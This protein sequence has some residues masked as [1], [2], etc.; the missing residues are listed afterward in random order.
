MTKILQD[1]AKKKVAIEASKLISDHMKLGIGTGSTVYFL[2]E[3][4]INHPKSNEI[5][6]A[7]SS[8]NS[9][10]LLERTAYHKFTDQNFTQLDLTIDGADYVDKNGVLIKGGGGALTRE[11]VLITA[12]KKSIILIDE[13]KWITEKKQIV[14][15]IEILPFGLNAT[16]YHLNKAGYKGNLRIK[17]DHSFFITDNGNYIYDVIIEFPFIDANKTHNELKMIT[18]VVETGIFIHF[19]I[20]VWIA[21]FDDK[22]AIQKHHFNN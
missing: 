1:F 20:E 19:P 7:F 14:L 6:L 2:I 5:Q 3:E 22:K 10:N 8:I 17:S 18:G 16:I 11:K 13:T 9:K 15:P 12:S 4:L 21:F